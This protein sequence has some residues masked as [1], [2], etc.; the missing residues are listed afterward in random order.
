MSTTIVTDAELQQDVLEELKWEPSVNSAAIG[1]ATRDG[2]VTLT[3]TVPSFMERFA[4]ERAAKRVYGVRA[5]V[6]EIEVKLPGTS[7][8]T[9]EDI[10]AAAVNALKSHIS[11]PSEKIKVTVSKG[12]VKLEGEVEWNYQRVAAENALRL[13]PGVVGVTNLITV[14]PRVSP[15]EIKL[16][17]ENALKRDA[18]LD[19]HRIS[20]EVE[21]G[22]VTLRGTVR[23]L[24]EKEEAERAAWSAPGA[25]IVENQITVAP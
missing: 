9:D 14:K 21:G 15:T 13:L 25:Y 6:N 19:A 1:V 23:S 24:A 20:V 8:R 12:L 2:I 11:I 22:K 4:A 3:G 16:K 18:E 10:A 17:I 7:R 5:V